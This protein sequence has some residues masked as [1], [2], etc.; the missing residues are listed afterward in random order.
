MGPIQDRTAER[1]GVSDRAVT[2]NR[3]LLLSAADAYQTGGKLPARPLDQ[4]AASGLTGPL[5]VDTVAPS[6]SWRQHWRMS[7]AERRRCSPWSGHAP[8]RGTGA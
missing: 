4:A 3:R 5:A 1:L 6:E 7:E 2:A 8:V